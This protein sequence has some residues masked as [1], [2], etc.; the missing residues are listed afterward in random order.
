M[1]GLAVDETFGQRPAI[2]RARGAHREDV[3]AAAHQKNLLV[4][5]MAEQLS[6]IGELGGRNAFRQIGAGNFALIL[7]HAL[8]LTPAASSAA[9][10]RC[11][12]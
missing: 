5:D 1:H 8:L 3:R 12:P 2:V 7:R 4:A 6:A 11:R 10:S 9:A